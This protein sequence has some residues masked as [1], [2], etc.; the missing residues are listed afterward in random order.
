MDPA[1]LGL[2]CAFA[3][4]AAWGTADYLAAHVTRRIG[5]TRTLLAIQGAGVPLLLLGWVWLAPRPP[6]PAS[7]AWI[8]LAAAAFAVG[9]L[10]FFYG[11][12]VGAVS[13]VS[14][15]SS[16]GAL[17]PVSAGIVLFGEEVS[18]SKLGGI[19]L[20]LTGLAIMLI[21]TRAVHDLG[22]VGRRR[23]I[24]AGVATMLAWGSGTAL[25]LP[26]VK[27]M[28]GF[29]PIAL[30]RLEILL[31]MVA[32]FVWRGAASRTESA[33]LGWSPALWA[34][35]VPAAILDLGAFVSYG[36]ALQTVP[37][38]IAAP[39][40]SAYPLITIVIARRLLHE[41]LSRKEWGGV[42]VTLAGT[43]ILG[44]G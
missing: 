44:F 31:A 38:S 33:P 20:T 10:S 29:A 39:I 42:A 12:R 22:S 43:A 5:V 26:L 15:I 17:I 21:D 24:V 6:T 1:S 11:L 9:Y 27:E 3:T 23:G 18:G 37:A 36:F 32:W 41:R 8:S 28:G 7:L 40:A 2:T 16:A 34:F 30:L 19:L 4:S 14:P 35:I 25:L 13:L